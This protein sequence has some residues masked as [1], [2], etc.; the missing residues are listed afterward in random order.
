LNNGN[1]TGGE[2]MSDVEDTAM[3]IFHAYED[4][5]L[6]KGKCKIFEE[7]FDKFLAAVDLEGK[8]EPYDAMVTLGRENRSE[9]DAMVKILKDQGLI[10]E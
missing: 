4:Y 3:K 8:A 1:I 2:E 7:L 5:C 10:S 9:F 6:D